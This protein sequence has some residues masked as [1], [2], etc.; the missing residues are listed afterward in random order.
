[1]AG[2]FTDY[3]LQGLQIGLGIGQYKD[4]R[5]RE[6]M[7]EEKTAAEEE[8]RNKALMEAL[9]IVYDLGPEP[10]TRKDIIESNIA[11]LEKRVSK[12]EGKDVLSPVGEAMRYLY[13]QGGDPAD[14][15]W[16]SQLGDVYERPAEMSVDDLIRMMALGEQG[17]PSEMMADIPQ[18]VE[19]V[20]FL[21]QFPAVFEE[22]DLI[23]PSRLAFLHK[24]MREGVVVDEETDA[25]A[26]Y[27]PDDLIELGLA[28][29]DDR[30]EMNLIMTA[31]GI[32]D[33]ILGDPGIAQVMNVGDG[34]IAFIREDGEIE[35]KQNPYYIS[36]LSM[37]SARGGGSRS[38]SGGSRSGGGGSRSGTAAA[39][40]TGMAALGFREDWGS[41]DGGYGR[42]WKN[43]A[44][45][46]I[47]P[48]TEVFS[49]LL[50]HGMGD[51]SLI[52]SADTDRAASYY[53]ER[54][55]ESEEGAI[56][57]Y[58][59]LKRLL[60]NHEINWEDF[61]EILGKLGLNSMI[62]NDEE[63]ADYAP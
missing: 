40:K 37:M 29:E 25:R 47:V 36:P 46:E 49:Y 14:I 21:E 6:R 4:E 1:M 62:A 23:D 42:Y 55:A 35:W 22:A 24:L 51:P 53:S 61:Y 58:E 59:E 38:G 5:Y 27:M 30:A 9:G 41:Y 45:G 3:F 50:E 2:N 48:D 57:T 52:P 20:P 54:V 60:L 7:A 56:S 44:T 28:G 19:E 34:T 8:K 13:A 11:D 12:A 63:I 18:F 39:T 16:I 10:E 15:Y 26:T 17:V 31:P 32:V 43:D 33:E